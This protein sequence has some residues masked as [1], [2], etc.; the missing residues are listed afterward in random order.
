MGT[1]IQRDALSLRFTRELLPDSE[2]MLSKEWLVTNGLGGYASGTLLGVATRRYHGIFVPDLP[3]PWGRTIMIPRLDEEAVIDGES[4]F[5]SGVEFEDGRLQ[6]DLP[7]VLSEFSLDRQTPVWRCAIKGRHL[8]KRVIMPYGQNSVYVEYRLLEGDSFRLRLR[9]FATFRMLDAQLSEARRPPCSLNVLEGRYE[10]HLSEGAPP[11]KMCLRPHGGV[12]VA[13]YLLS[14]GVSYRVDKDRGSE[15]IE[16]LASPGYFAV[17]LTTAGADLV[18]RK[19][20]RLGSSS[21][22]GSTHFRG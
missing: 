22:R 16:D 4:F 11:L 12:F 7:Q 3:S 9:P 15:H 8:E 21:V 19:H 2:S 10:M 1:T 14:R 20:R 5:L 17:D 13:D 6:G 18:C